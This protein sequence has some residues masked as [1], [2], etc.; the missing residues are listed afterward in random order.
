M[1]LSQEKEQRLRRLITE[2]RMMEGTVEALN[3]RLALL[4][5]AITELR[6]ATRSLGELKDIELN[7]PLLVPIGGGTFVN[8]TLGDIRKVIIG[9]G[10]DVSV[11]MVYEDAFQDINNRLLEMEKVQISV[12]QQIGQVISQLESHQAM[13]QRLSTEINGAR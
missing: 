6:L 1:T 13:V 10:A 3:Q 11:E 2:I 12:H 9:I 5:S 4:N 8:A 7:N